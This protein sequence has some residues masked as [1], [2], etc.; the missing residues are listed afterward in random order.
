MYTLIIASLISTLALGAEVRKLTR[1]DIEWGD[2]STTVTSP[3]GHVGH[4]IDN[5]YSLSSPYVDV[6]AYGAS[7]SATAVVNNAAFASAIAAVSD[8]GVLFIPPGTYR[9]HLIVRRN[10]ITIMAYGATIKAEDNVAGAWT[11]LEIGDTASG[12]SATAYDNVNVLGITLDGN[13]D[14]TTDPGNDLN[15]WGIATT[16][17][18][19]GNFRDIK[20]INCWN[21]GAGTFINSN[22][23]RWSDIY[24]YNCGFGA[25]NEPGFDVNS[26]KYNSFKGIVVEACNYGFRLLDNCHGNEADV[27]IYNPTILGVVYNNQA[28]N[29]SKANIIRAT[30]VNGGS[31]GAMTV[32][33][34]CSASQIYLATDNVTGYGLHIQGPT[35]IAADNQSNGNY[36]NVTTKGSGLQS[37]KVYSDRNRIDVS[38]NQDGR[39][40]AQGDNFAVDVHGDNNVINAIVEDTTTW[41]VRGVVFRS[42]ADGNR[43]ESLRYINTANP[44]SDSGSSNY[45]NTGGWGDNLASSSTISP[46]WWN[47]P[48]FYLTGTDNVTTITADSANGKQITLISTDNVTIVNGSNIKLGSNWVSGGDNATLT[49]ISN[50]TN[51]YEIGRRVN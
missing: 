50:G 37:V 39:S 17:I 10:N 25:Q 29:S 2:P 14:G 9:G 20:A 40:G 5:T 51:W 26:S 44:Y 36:Y 30:V 46:K 49:L 16:K 3:G 18:S 15:G 34:N 43:L 35:D 48:I 32:G 13:K 22:Y 38:S 28:V 27:I 6:R 4:R 33:A 11:V 42:G 23:N 21:G 24:V 31:S 45:F 1:E 8:F 47:G 41:Q 7:A 19:H 12:N